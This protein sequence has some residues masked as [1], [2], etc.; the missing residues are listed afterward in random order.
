MEKEKDALNNSKTSQKFTINNTKELKE[1][2]IKKTGSKKKKIKYAVLIV[3]LALLLGHVV[4]K[5]IENY[6][7][8]QA[9]ISAT[10]MQDGEFD[11]NDKKELITRGTDLALD[12][13]NAG[14]EIEGEDALYFML[15][16]GN[17]NL[18]EKFIRDLNL[19]NTTERVITDSVDKTLIS[20]K[21]AV[22]GGKEVSLDTYFP[23]TEDKELIENILN[24]M[25]HWN[26]ADKQQVADAMYKL[27]DYMFIKGQYQRYSPQAVVTYIKLFRGFD[28]LTINSGYKLASEDMRNLIYMDQECYTEENVIE[29]RSI[30]SEQYA[31]VKEILNEKFNGR[32]YD[33]AYKEGVGYEIITEI[34]KNILTSNIN[35]GTSTDVQAE[36]DKNNT[37]IYVDN[38][39]SDKYVPPIKEEEKQQIKVDKNTGEEY[40]LQTKTEEEKQQERVEI[41][42]QI[43]ENAEVKVDASKIQA[44]WQE[45][46]DKGFTDGVEGLSKT[47][48]AGKS[49]YY[50][51][52]YEYGYSTGYD[53]YKMSLEEDE[54]IDETFVPVEEEVVEKE[55]TK[56]TTSTNKS[57]KNNSTT[58]TKPSTESAEPTT[59]VESSSSFQFVDGFYEYDGIVYDSE[60]NMMLDENGNPFM[61][62]EYSSDEKTR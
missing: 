10:Q 2:D 53:M 20:V 35:L 9:E 34:N 22:I 26:S 4:H 39:K 46:H 50:I 54:L 32:E 30:H 3:I 37:V 5:S 28:E 15:F 55:T 43:K 23:E 19:S 47:S 7:E 8:N 48:T 36:R 38:P 17:N 31:I 12:L 25:G 62:S 59:K 24:I 51:K 40:I 1:K 52:G 61:I 56:K 60:G 29:G 16:A 42:E 21:D 27:N 33:K 57:N 11:I 14:Y 58:T 13:R 41:E 45:G 18:D 6:K 49:E 44:E